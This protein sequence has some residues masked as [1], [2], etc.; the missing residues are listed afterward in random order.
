LAHDEW[1]TESAVTI[2]GAW[3]GA[4]LWCTRIERGNNFKRSRAQCFARQRK[5]AYS[6]AHMQIVNQRVTKILACHFQP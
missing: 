5:D 6:Q 4:R 1:Q 2:V 3:F